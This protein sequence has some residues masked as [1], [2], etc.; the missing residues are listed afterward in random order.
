VRSKPKR[1]LSAVEHKKVLDLLHSEAFVD[2]A[3][4]EVWASLLDMEIY[5]CSIRTMY[6]ILAANNEVRERR[7]QRQH[8]VY[9]KPELL[10]TGTHQVYSWDI[11]KLRGPVKGSFYYLYVMIDIFSRYVVGWMVARR[12]TAVLAEYFLKRSCQSQGIKPGHLVIHSDRGAPMTSHLVAQLFTDLGVQKSVSRPHV[13]NDNSYSES[14]FKTLKYRPEF[15][16][17]FGSLQD[18]RVHCKEFFHW[19]NH[20][21]YHSGIGLLTPAVVHSGQSQTWMDK[22]QQVLNV[23][24]QAHPERFVRHA[25]KPPELALQVWINAP[26]KTVETPQSDAK[27]AGCANL[28]SVEVA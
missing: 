28:L 1:A 26:V 9:A 24:Y 21:H 14:Q 13:S 11:T 4:S 18:A 10:A 15:P 27:T 12:E 8:P 3:P 25:P 17:R 7:N 6:R 22:R 2:K 19:Y 16:D 5:L 20:E 23:A